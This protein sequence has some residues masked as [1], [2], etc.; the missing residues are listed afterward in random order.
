MNDVMKM[1]VPKKLSSRPTLSTQGFTLLEVVV[2]LLILAIMGAMLA[3]FGIKIMIGSVEPA[4]QTQEI[5]N[6][7]QVMENITIDYNRL[8][9]DEPK[10]LCRLADKVSHPEASGYGLYSARIRFLKTITRSDGVDQFVETGTTSQNCSSASL[11]ESSIL[12]IT[13]F[14]PGSTQGVSVSSLF[15]VPNS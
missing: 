10:A 13:L 8:I 14:S 15:T 12:E 9:I 11:R 3:N 7:Q 6:L 4:M 5:Y 2:S 1:L